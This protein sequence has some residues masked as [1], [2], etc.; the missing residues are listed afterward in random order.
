MNEQPTE[1]DIQDAATNA[2][3]VA[4][5][6]FV[7]AVWS[8]LDLRAAWLLTDPLLRRCWAQAWLAE[9][10]DLTR[11]LGYDPDDVV[12]AFTADRP[13][14]DLW[15]DFEATQMPSLLAAQPG[16]LLEWGASAHP[17]PVDLDTELVWLRSMPAGQAEAVVNGPGVPFVM[18]FEDGPGWRVLNFVS[19]RVPVPGWPPVL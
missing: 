4:V 19:E 2:P 10:H 16:N 18:R 3:R 1:Q 6:R 13:E 7:S 17:E 9:Q 11:S 14:H 5:F 15:Q 8:D 12:E